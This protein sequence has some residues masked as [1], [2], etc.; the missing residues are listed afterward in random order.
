MLPTDIEEIIHSYVDK[1]HY[2]ESLP[3]VKSVHRLILKSNKSLV[4]SLVGN[5][6]VPP[7]VISG[8]ASFSFAFLLTAHNVDIVESVIGECLNYCIHTASVFWLFIKSQ[9]SIYHG[10][11]ARLFE[12]KSL[13]FHLINLVAMPT[14]DA[15]ESTLL[16]LKRRDRSSAYT[17]YP[18]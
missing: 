5:G 16:C 4:S 15:I 1:F 12:Q 13:L 10:P 9:P 2:W 11:Y 18:I 8:V 3:S 14:G 17:L 7:H 6:F